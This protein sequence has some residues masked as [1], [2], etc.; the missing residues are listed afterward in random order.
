MK[1]SG[2][3]RWSLQCESGSSL[4]TEFSDQVD[5]LAAGRRQP[6]PEIHEG[7][8][9]RASVREKM[10]SLCFNPNK[11][12]HLDSQLNG[13]PS[14]HML[15]NALTKHA[16]ALAL[17]TDKCLLVVSDNSCQ[18]RSLKNKMQLNPG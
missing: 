8:R 14:G 10:N 6:G 2:K 5:D 18:K 13:L 7:N 11:A 12:E 15:F 16:N 17:I 1:Q 4:L 9:R 3:Q